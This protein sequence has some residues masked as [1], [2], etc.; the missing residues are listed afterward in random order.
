MKTRF[1]ILMSF[2]AV[3]A[4]S[5]SQTDPVSV[6]QSTGTITVNFTLPAYTLK[7]TLLTDL[8][9]VSEIFKFIELN[10]FG[11]I[12]DIGYPQLPQYTFD[13]HT[14]R[15]QNFTVTVS[16]Q[17]TEQITLNRRIYPTQEDIG[18]EDDPTPAFQLNQ[19][20]Y[21]STGSLY[22]HTYQLSEPFIVFGEKGIS[23]T[24]FP[25]LSSIIRKPAHLPL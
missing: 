19:S 15:A 12:E 6:S 5:F 14:P 1:I 24:I 7:D 21:A 11:I 22:N 8:Y 17:V 9:D 10:D 3:S 20:Y 25:F 4:N 16:G 23:M 2:F 13:L 18:S